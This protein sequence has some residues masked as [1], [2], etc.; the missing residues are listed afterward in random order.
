MK[1]KKKNTEEI[2]IDPLQQEEID[3]K[4]K[5]DKLWI[6]LITSLV[7]YIG[8]VMVTVYTLGEGTLS[9]IIISSS[10]VI[11]VF[12]AFYTLKLE[13]EIGYYECNKCHHR[14]KPSYV[15]ALFA[16]HINTTRYMRCPECDKISWS[17][18]VMTK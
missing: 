5:M 9:G 18:K 7:L 8:I 10:T 3:N 17:K 15:K 1:D 16:P 6:I 14:Y 4:K 12:V 13:V 2:L 11:F